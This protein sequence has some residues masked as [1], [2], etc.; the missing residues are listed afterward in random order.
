MVALPKS[1]TVMIDQIYAAI[2]KAEKGEHRLT[3][4]GASGIGNECLRATWLSWRGYARS[5]FDGRMYRLFRTGHLQEDRIVEDL[6]RAGFEVWSHQEDG[7]QY[8]Y[9][10]STGHFVAKL[11]GVVR[12]VPGAEKTPHDLEVKTH[13][14]KSFTELEKKGV[15][16]SKPGHYYQMQAGMLYSGLPRALYVALCKDNEQYYV[17]RVKPDPQYTGIIQRRIDTLVNAELIPAGVSDDGGA[18]AC[19]WCDM[20]SACMGEAQPIRTCRS[21]V[22]AVVV[23]EGGAWGCALTG[24]VLSGAEQLKAC[25]EYEVKAVAK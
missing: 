8:T 21:C 23:P 10:D 2:E 13:S 22:N 4:L 18:F 19:K 6:R 20:R 1:E 24:G 7:E 12:G 25:D 11:D 17:E 14:K 3:R 15:E 9:N 16:L 5:T